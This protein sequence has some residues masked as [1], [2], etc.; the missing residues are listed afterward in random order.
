MCPFIASILL[1]SFLIPV[2]K[3]LTCFSYTHIYSVFHALRAHNDLAK[4]RIVA[5]I[6]GRLQNCFDEVK[7][8][9]PKFPKSF[10]VSD[11]PE[12]GFKDLTTVAKM[13]KFPE[14]LEILNKLR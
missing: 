13:S 4:Q 3:S 12:K 8:A 2:N 7:K 6:P 14:Q 11:D 1:Y 9:V 10:F 5:T